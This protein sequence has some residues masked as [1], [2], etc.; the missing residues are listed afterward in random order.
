MEHKLVMSPPDEV[1]VRPTRTRSRTRSPSRTKEIIEEED[2]DYLKDEFKVKDHFAGYENDELCKED[3]IDYTNEQPCI[4]EPCLQDM[5][6]CMGYATIDKNKPYDPPLP[7]ARTPPTPPR[8]RKAKAKKDQ[9]KTEPRFFTVPRPLKDEA[10]MRPLR[11]YSTLGPGERKKRSVQNL[12]DEEKG[13]VDITQYIEI[14]EHKDLQSGEVIKKMKDRPLPAP[15]RPPRKTRDGT[16]EVLSDITNERELPEESEVST[17]TEPLPDDFVCED[18]IQEQSDRVLAPR[19]SFDNEETITHGSLVIERFT[20]G[21]FVNR[22]DISNPDSSNVRIIKV[23]KEEQDTLDEEFDSEIPEDFHNLKSS[24]DEKKML[25]DLESQIVADIEPTEQYSSISK[26]REEVTAQKP[27]TK[28]IRHEVPDPVEIPCLRASKL[29]VT[30]LDVDCL[31]VNELLA[32]KIKVS[33]IDS[34]QIQVSEINSKG[35]NLVVSGIE[36]PAGFLK[37][38]LGKLQEEASKGSTSADRREQTEPT[39]ELG[40]SGQKKTP[41][42]DRS[43]ETVPIRPPRRKSEINLDDLDGSEV[44]SEEVASHFDVQQENLK[45]EKLESNSEQFEHNIKLESGFIQLQG[46]IQLES[47]MPS[48]SSGLENINPPQKPQRQKSNGKKDNLDTII[49]PEAANVELVSVVQKETHIYEEIELIKPVA[50]EGTKHSEQIEKVEDVDAN[51]KIIKQEINDEIINQQISNEIINQSINNE[52]INQG[53]NNEI[54]NQEINNEI[55]NQEINNGIV[56]ED[57]EKIPSAAVSIEYRDVTEELG[58]EKCEISEVKNIEQIETQIGDITKEI[59]PVEEVICQKLEKSISPPVK[60]QRNSRKKSEVDVEIDSEDTLFQQISSKHMLLEEEDEYSGMPSLM[61]QESVSEDVQ[62]NRNLEVA[63][64]QNVTESETYRKI[65]ESDGYKEDILQTEEKSVDKLYETTGED[66]GVSDKD[67]LPSERKKSLTQDEID[68]IE[69][70]IISSLE[71]DYEKEIGD[72][73]LHLKISPEMLAEIQENFLEEIRLMQ[74]PQRPAR[75]KDEN[76]DNKSEVESEI[77]NNKDKEVNHES[78]VCL[79]E[80]KSSE[81]F[82]RNQRE[83]IENSSNESPVNDSPSYEIYEGQP[84]QDEVPPPRPPQPLDDSFD[85]VPSQPP[86]SFFNLRS[87]VFIDFIDEDIPMAPR[88]RRTKPPPV[89]KTSSEDNPPT[90]ST[91]RRQ[92]TPEPSIPQLAGQ[93]TNA[94]GTAINRS[95][96]RLITHLTDNVLN[97]TD[98]KQDLHVI[99]MML[100]LLIAALML[101]GF[102]DMKQVHHHHWEYFNPPKNL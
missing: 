73:T 48:E 91:R 102:G 85:Y 58:I 32:N 76:K 70:R 51:E 23:S 20:D 4:E 56:N 77:E 62:N 84:Y 24:V 64:K 80:S 98:G 36:L 69:K 12:T 57:T 15:P 92:R 99:I 33:E 7:P 63:T 88:R 74:Q 17:Q 42:E 2:E 26:K 41:F 31:K 61:Q 45:N 53:I 25:E 75:R 52:N 93:L 27:T 78:E 9:S 35:G 79:D 59:N 100:L 43:I 19:E 95:F 44:I 96:K 94:C 21:N 72:E 60:P 29:Q 18:L 14:D 101:L 87:P 8:R 22:V 71:E 13:N 83:F 86:P 66:G 6:D 50:E 90:T 39:E 89:E 28:Q 10:P 40:E 37:E 3:F 34:S 11:N 67:N 16:K 46:E 54:N 30:D 65:S 55:I 1:P 82:I 49:L 97:N 47:D 38:L 81:D 68:E 5:R